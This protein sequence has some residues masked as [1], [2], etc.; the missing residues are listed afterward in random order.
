MTQERD[1]RHSVCAGNRPQ[2]FRVGY[3]VPILLFISINEHL[4]IHRDTIL[5]KAQLV[6]NCEFL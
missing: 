2:S 3:T 1:V 6:S 4:Y 5:G